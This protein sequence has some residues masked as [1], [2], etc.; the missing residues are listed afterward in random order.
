MA[1]LAIDIGEIE[2]EIEEIDSFIEKIA[3]HVYEWNVYKEYSFLSFDKEK[4]GN[5]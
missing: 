1:L 4:K 3:K 5:W 2:V